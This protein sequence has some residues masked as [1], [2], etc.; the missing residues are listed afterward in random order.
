MKLKVK[1]LN[2]IAGR[3]IVILTKET[4]KK[5]NIHVNER[6]LVKHKSRRIYAVVDIFTELLK[7][8]EI[9]L[10]KEISG[11]LKT[12]KDSFVE[13]SIAEAYIAS[14]IIKKKLEGA[15]LNQQE[16]DILIKEI[17]SNNLTEQE[18][19]YFIAAEKLNGMSTAETISLTRSMITNGKR[20]LF[21][22]YI[23]A[24]KHCIGGI[25]GNRTTP[26]VVSICAAAGLK[27]PKSSSRAITSASGTADVMETIANVEHSAESI[28]KIVEKTN[29]CLVWGGSLGLA[30]SDD[31]IIH[32]ERVLNL[33]VEPQMIASILSKKISAGSTHVLI[34]IPY[35]GGK[36]KNIW[37]ARRLGNKFSSIA[38]YFG[39]IVL[40]VYTDGKQP[41][42]KG[43]GPVLEMFDVLSVLQN[44]EDSPRDLKEKSI[45]L[46]YQLMNLC[47]IK[48]AKEKAR[49][50]LESGEAYKKFIEIINAQNNSDDFHDR[51]KRLRLGR[52]SK[53]ILAQ[54]DGKIIEINNGKINSLCRIL[55]TPQTITS[56]VY[57]HKQLGK[58]KRN[59]VIM[60]LY[61]E[62]MDRLKDAEE[63]LETSNPIRIDGKTEGVI[64]IKQDKA[65]P[66]LMH[67]KPLPKL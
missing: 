18:I 43:F 7:G 61:S 13:V 63:F 60:T 21:D 47:G 31:K 44:K 51:V 65:I 34:D 20:L 32:V 67:H 10:S 50:I 39:L 26:I 46:A 2:W 5:L 6:V 11:F 28:K 22:D 24:D 12:E 1:N 58:V 41:I 52:Y 62:S 36:M 4:S 25:A 38:K 53:E 66:K 45:Y 14:S 57:L 3:P 35:G 54:S 19:A 9:G 17:N 64:I 49:N 30:P 29:A 8:E 23:I 56:G 27:M 42:G 55:G 40:P 16:I 59:E 15:S 48:N 33:D 37:Q